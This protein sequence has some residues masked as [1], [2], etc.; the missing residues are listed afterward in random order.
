MNTPIEKQDGMIHELKDIVVEE[1]SLVDRAANKRRFLVVKRDNTMK[2]V[3]TD[4]QG[5]LTTTENAEGGAGSVSV[6]EVLTKAVSELS[7]LHNIFEAGFT[8]EGSEELEPLKKEAEQLVSSLATLLG[9]E[10]VAEPVA[11]EASDTKP[12]VE[13]EAEQAL[14][15]EQSDEQSDAEADDATGSEQLEVEKAGRKLSGKNE[16]EL[17]GALEN[18]SRVLSG[19]SGKEKEKA[20]QKLAEAAAAAA[21]DTDEKE[22]GYGKDKAKKSESVDAGETD[23]TM[24]D[25]VA[26][27]EATVAKQREEL[28]TL[29]K[30]RPVSNAAQVE[31]GD[32][33]VPTNKVE[34]P[35]DMNA[36]TKERF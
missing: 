23:A 10:K 13:G 29:R 4:E 22:K 17:R 33:E 14:K 35:L 16:K 36:K 2:E 26:E 24:D 21:K 30:A 19:L 11:S 34:W 8:A 5:N 18:I 28:K 20:K 27:L 31:S 1:V 7:H 15:S 3:K 32:I 6:Q 25:K 12:D 9:I